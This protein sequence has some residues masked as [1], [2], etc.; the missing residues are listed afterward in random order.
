MWADMRDDPVH[1]R[2]HIYYTRSDDRG[3]SWG[4]ELEEFGYR[5][6]DTRVTDFPSNP[7]R[8]FPQGLFIGDYF[9]IA[10]TDTDVYMVWADTR[11]AEFGGVNQKIG[12]ARRRPIRSPDIFVSPPAGPGGQNITVQGFNFQP[13]MTVFITLEDATI[14]SARTNLDGRFTTSLYVPITGEG[15]QRLAVYDLSGNMASTSY[16]TEFGFGSMETLFLDLLDEVR[17]LRDALRSRE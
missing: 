6:R 3:T 8:G 7:N 13:D 1:I 5:V 9:G 4:F 11:L 10:A 14:A 16:Y 15:P 17:D 2:Y 12:F